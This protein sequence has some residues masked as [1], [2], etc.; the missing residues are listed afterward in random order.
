MKK[1]CAKAI[2]FD[3]QLL[4]KVIIMSKLS[5]LLLTCTVFTLYAGNS[6]SQQ[7]KI[8]LEMKNAT[9]SDVI[10]AIKK[11]TEFEFAYDSN[12]EKLIL[13]NVSIHAKNENIDNVL[14]LLLQETDVNYKVIDKIILLSKNPVK[15]T[16][17][18]E[19]STQQLKV[20]GTITDASNGAPLPG[21]NIVIQGTTIGTVSD[22]DGNYNIAVPGPDAALVFSF[23]GYV[24]ETV[25][26]NGRSSINLSM[27]S[28]IKDLQEVVV[29]GYGTRKKETL[30]GAISKING[31]DIKVNPS[32]NL[33]SSLGGKI[34]GVV[35]VNYSGQPG[36]DGSK[37]LIRGLG[38][39]GNNNPLIIVDGIE[40]GS[41][42]R[43]D[44]NDIESLSVLKD[45]SAAIYGSK[46]A[47]GVII[48]T[49]KRGTK[50]KPKVEYGYNIG[51]GQPTIKPEIA[52]AYEYNKYINAYYAANNEADKQMP[53]ADL[54]KLRTGV[55][56]DNYFANTD[57][58][59]TVVRNY[60]PIQR[61]TAS[62][63]GGTEE[64]KYFVSVGYL[65]QQSVFKNGADAFT[66]NNYRTNL[67][68]Q[69]NKYIKMGI[70]LNGR[71]DKKT[72]PNTDMRDIWWMTQAINPR[73]PAYFSNGLP[74]E[75]KEDGW[76]PVMMVSDAGGTTVDKT[77]SYRNM[78]TYE[79][80]MPWVEGL[81]LD[82]W[83]SLDK[84]QGNNRRQQYPWTVY[85]RENA[86]GVY[87]P[88]ISKRLSQVSLS[89]GSNWATT[90]T[91]HS[92]VTYAKKIGK[93]DISAF[94]AYEQNTYEYKWISSYRNGIIS[95][96][97]DAQ[98]FMGSQL[99]QVANGSA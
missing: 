63:R 72:K 61:H 12:L 34:P 62:I 18:I 46:A 50:G 48:V 33:T 67:D 39:L 31:T 11:Q 82:G 32:P 51:L 80:K 60:A 56:P 93:H 4:R 16:S 23:I 75:G 74:W 47:N 27:V 90:Q 81:A 53:E 41:I 57:W 70:N 58:W 55:D 68:W 29:V 64:L 54:E 86:D 66:Q 71:F 91:F 78:V 77:N 28:D 96:N 13:K 94:V 95:T 59:N 17:G 3:K 44:P 85:G 9:L 84:S 37:I 6:Y 14:S 38:T 1:T 83:Y 99:G 79:I 76:N 20:T 97:P 89:E 98:L 65:D 40:A 24:S 36:E 69:L 26:V 35:S 7:V 30:T 73:F 2:A 21:V 49:T 19:R 92:K 43:I 87:P 5:L 88:S 42:D 25:K 52:N 10:N 15:T 8:N 22:I 45:A